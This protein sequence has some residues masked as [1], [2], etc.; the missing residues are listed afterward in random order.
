MIWAYA[1]TTCTQRLEMTLPYTLYDLAMAGFDEP[2]VSLDSNQLCSLEQVTGCKSI[3]T[4]YP[5]LGAFG[6]WFATL[7]ELRVRN[8]KATMFAIFQDDVIV[9]YGLRE[10]LERNPCPDNGYMNLFTAPSNQDLFGSADDATWKEARTLTEETDL[11]TGR[12]ALG[13]VFTK[14]VVGKLLAS[15]ILTEK[16]LTVRHPTKCI[17]GA[18][19]QAL[20]RVGVREY[21]HHTSLIQHREVESTV[22]RLVHQQATSFE[23]YITGLTHREEDSQPTDLPEHVDERRTE[24]RSGDLQPAPEADDTAVGSPTVYAEEQQPE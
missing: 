2:H 12:G 4:H 23:P 21:V 16:P 24:D 19:V 15:P 10:Y 9:T 14:D 7:W 11:Q 18:V 6:N 8:P 17:D 5:A 1:V 22:G 13:L 3:T 20:N